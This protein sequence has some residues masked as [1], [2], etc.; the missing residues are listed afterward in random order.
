MCIHDACFQ[1]FHD[2]DS[3]KMEDDRG[4]N[5]DNIGL[6]ATSGYSELDGKKDSVASP[7]TTENVKADNVE[8]SVLSPNIS[9]KKAMVRQRSIPPPGTGQRIYEIDPFLRSHRDHLDYR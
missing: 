3:T 2:A 8:P 5:D 7:A 9:K 1:I 4:I 6:E